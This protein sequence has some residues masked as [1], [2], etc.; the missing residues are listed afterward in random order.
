MTRARPTAAAF[1]LASLFTLPY[2]PLSL[3]GGP[4][5]VTDIVVTNGK[6]KPDEP[7]VKHWFLPGQLVWAR[8]KVSNDGAAPDPQ[9]KIT[10]QAKVEFAPGPG[11]K[12]LPI[13]PVDS[14]L[15]VAPPASGQTASHI[16][17]FHTPTKEGLYTVRVS[18]DSQPPDGY[19]M[20]HSSI[21]VQ[22]ERPALFVRKA[23]VMKYS[24]WECESGGQ[25]PT[26]VP[27]GPFIGLDL[28]SEGGN[29]TPP[30][31]ARV[32]VENFG[33]K[34]SKPFKVSLF[35]VSGCY[36]TLTI[37]MPAIPA[38]KSAWVPKPV[39]LEKIPVGSCNG[40]YIVTIEPPPNEGGSVGA[41]E[42][43]FTDVDVYYSKAKNDTGQIASFIASH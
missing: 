14:K 43:T 16:L 23:R 11:Q 7:A 5:A 31:Q 37:A 15:T 1:V 17:I 29:C 12:A 13:A 30:D 34:A 10:L 8:A 26:I 22:S 18:L 20:G 36:S 25:G 2:P 40:P 41:S 24:G 4:Y 6:P 19:Y 35:D 38:K 33:A 42:L 9:E 39:T 28:S 32:K 21:L 27:Y 3:A